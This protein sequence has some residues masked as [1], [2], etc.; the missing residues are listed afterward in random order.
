MFGSPPYPLPGRPN[1]DA[2]RRSPMELDNLQPADKHLLYGF[3]LRRRRS[4]GEDRAVLE[5]IRRRAG[6]DAKI[7]ALLELP[8]TVP[9]GAASSNRSRTSRP[10]RWPRKLPAVVVDTPGKLFRLLRRCGLRRRL[11]LTTARDGLEALPLIRHLGAR[12]LILNQTTGLPDL[13]RYATICRA[14][15]PRLRLVFLSPEH[16][17]LPTVPPP[18]A[19]FVRIMAKPIRVD[20][21]E[22]TVWELLEPGSPVPGLSGR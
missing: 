8:G 16:A 21:L 4:P 14:V 22:Q 20:Q 7:S 3:L 10:S 13:V 2:G 18:L 19:P 17:A 9:G 1:T 6:L 5:I 15:E 11:V 12:L